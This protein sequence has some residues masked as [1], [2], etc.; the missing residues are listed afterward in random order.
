MFKL[1]R[2]GKYEDRESARRAGS[3]K[4]DSKG[5]KIGISSGEKKLSEKSGERPKSVALLRG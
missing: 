5:A 3:M 1:S 4:Q 2:L